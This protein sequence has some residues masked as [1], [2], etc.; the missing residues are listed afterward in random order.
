MA[1]WT[2]NPM[3]C[4][5]ASRLDSINGRYGP[6]AFDASSEPSISCTELLTSLTNK[7][8]PR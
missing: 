8:L 5:A 7:L 6:V 4:Q 3:D 1:D 2:K